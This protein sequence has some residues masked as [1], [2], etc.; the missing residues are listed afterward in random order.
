MNK[1][2]GG[3]PPID[4]PTLG[5]ILM[6]VA[7]LLWVIHD[8][9]SK[10]LTETY[11]LFQIVAVR[12][13]VAFAPISLI[14]YREQGLSR[15]RSAS[16]WPLL[17]RGALGAT[18]FVLF[19][20]AL[21]LMPLADIFAIV[22]SA[23]LVITALSV[24]LLGERVGA[25]R[26]VAVC[27]GFVAMLI[28]TR[29]GGAIVPLGAALVCGS[30]LFY[31]LAMISTRVLG[32]GESA[33]VITFYSNLVFLLVGAIA[34]PFVWIAPSRVDLLVM[35]ATGVLAGIAQ[36]AMTQAF[37]IAPPSVVA[38]FEYTSMIWA[39]LIGFAVWGEVPTPMVAL[40]A[41]VIIASGLYVLHRERKQMP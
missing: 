21:P 18:S 29:P 41:V 9:L 10:W 14:L 27:T 7:V 22:M 4:N 32:R 23:P 16:I 33:G 20:A 1:A 34:V 8:A 28:M 26:W 30:V 6:V 3:D 12:G 25:R 5:I 11:S 39:V 13:V 17:G 24:V 40:G 35:A 2:R 15:V 19:L 31:A 38:P 36:Y 37:R